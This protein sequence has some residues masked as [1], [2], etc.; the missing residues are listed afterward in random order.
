M[1]VQKY[2]G[3]FSLSVMT[4]ET[5]KWSLVPCT[6]GTGSA[7]HCATLLAPI[8]AL[9]FVLASP[10]C[11][12]PV[13]RFPSW[14]GDFLFLAPLL[15]PEQAPVCC[16]RILS[17][18]RYSLLKRFLETNAGVFSVLSLFSFHFKSHWAFRS[19]LSMAQ[20]YLGH[21]WPGLSQARSF[22][23]I[24]RGYSVTRFFIPCLASVIGLGHG[25]YP[26][27]PH[28]LRGDREGERL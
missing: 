2:L 9:C 23:G 14:M 10:P 28:P 25:K 13:Q 12:G 22:V 20:N 11:C 19:S 26:R 5:R 15:T 8:L 18:S 21:H 3:V 27:G 7:H 17:E 4:K 6:A 1:D 24:G 16:V